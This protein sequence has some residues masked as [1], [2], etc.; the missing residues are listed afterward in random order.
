MDD[1]NDPKKVKWKHFLSR[2]AYSNQVGIFEGGYY[3]AKGLYR[4]EFNS[5][6]S[7]INFA[8]FNGPS[9]EAIVRRIRQIMNQPFDSDSF[10]KDD[11]SD[12][13]PII[14]SSSRMETKIIRHDFIG[15]E[16]H[17]LMQRSKRQ[18]ILYQKQRPSLN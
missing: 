4:P 12:I 8:N 5:T 7:D 16:N 13:K 18:E 1:T 6:M 14:V 11:A 15:I 10:F 17:I 9:R 3:R 2:P